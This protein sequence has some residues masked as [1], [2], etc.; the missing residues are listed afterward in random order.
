MPFGQAVEQLP[1]QPGPGE[2]LVFRRYALPD[3]GLERR[4]VGL[5]QRG[6]ELVVD[7]R[8]HGLQDVLDR[9]HED[10]VLP[11]QAVV[12]IGFGEGHLDFPGVADL[13]ADELLLEALDEAAR[14]Q[15]HM[16]VL[17]GHAGIGLAVD[18]A[19]EVD[20]QDV[21]GLRFARRVQRLGL[22]VRLG[23]ILDRFLDRAV[24]DLD[25]AALQ[26]DLGKIHRLD[27]RKQLELH[28]VLEVLALVEGGDLDLGLYGGTQAAFAERLVR[29]VADRPLQDLAH[30]R[31]AETLLEDLQRHLAR[32]E[33]GDFHGAAEL[34]QPRHH[35]L[36][37]LR[38]GDLNLVF[39]L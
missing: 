3:T 37:D 18:G 36:V 32:A 28:G 4:Q 2:V 27:V 33:A 25:I 13:G 17:G 20:H 12:G 19:R 23:Q 39:P 10:R 14:A 8:R 30:H 7:G 35:L 16:V 24:L 9:H 1:L 31:L 21:A 5:S 22:L 11:G 15:L 29:T 38:G 34:L 26:F 6:R